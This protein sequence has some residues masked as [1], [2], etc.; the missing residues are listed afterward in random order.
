M[1]VKCA[2]GVKFGR[3]CLKEKLVIIILR[4]MSELNTGSM[5][6]DCSLLASTQTF[7]LRRVDTGKQV[8]SAFFVPEHAS[9]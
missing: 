2:L 5:R 7:I 3:V 6:A 8:E 4:M 1:V 9:Q